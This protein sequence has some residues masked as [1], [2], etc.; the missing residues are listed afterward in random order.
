MYGNIVCHTFYMAIIAKDICKSAVHYGH[1]SEKTASNQKP[2][3]EMTPRNY[4]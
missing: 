1:T 3:A 2:F 4:R